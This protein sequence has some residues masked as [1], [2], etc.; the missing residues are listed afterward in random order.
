MVKKVM[1]TDAAVMNQVLFLAQLFQLKRSERNNLDNNR[2]G[3]DPKLTRK[4]LS[5]A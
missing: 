4:S 3:G 1:N 2:I 5:P